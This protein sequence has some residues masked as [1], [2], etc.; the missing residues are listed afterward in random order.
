MTDRISADLAAGRLRQEG[1][2][3][4]VISDSDYSIG[5][6]TTGTPLQF[7][8]LVPSDREDEARR[9]LAS[10]TEEHRGPRRRSRDGSRRRLKG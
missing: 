4:E 6:A 7:S 8:L 2:P 5:L 1:V 9:V 3:V 10:I